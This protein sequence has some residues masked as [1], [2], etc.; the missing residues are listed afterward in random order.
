MGDVFFYLATGACLITAIVLILGI[1][2]LG[3]GKV[4]PKGQNKLMQLR[5]LAQFVAVILI[6]VTVVLIKG[7]K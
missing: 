5:I 4:T 3:T 1:R 2:G 6:L 7:D